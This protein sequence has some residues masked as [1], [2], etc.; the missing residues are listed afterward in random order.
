MTAAGLFRYAGILNPSPHESTRS[1]FPHFPPSLLWHLIS[2]PYWEPNCSRDIIIGCRSKLCSWNRVFP[3]QYLQASRQRISCTWPSGR[4][5][6]RGWLQGWMWNHPPKASCTSRETLP[7]TK[8]RQKATHS[9]GSKQPWAELLLR[10]FC[11]C[12]C[13]NVCNVVTGKM[14]CFF[15][16][17]IIILG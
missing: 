4:A 16:F 9:V 5:T 12:L 13:R 6:V 15:G 7:G 2:Q 14:F 10:L 3:S 8:R 11:K 17:R 1:I